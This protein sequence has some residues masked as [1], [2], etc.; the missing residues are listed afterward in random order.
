MSK[1][2]TEY[3]IDHCANVRKAYEWLVS[4][5][6]IA[7][8]FM[9]RIHTHDLSK[10]SDDEYGA[11]DKYFYGK[12]KT[13]EV[14]EAFNFAWLHHIHANPH[15]WQHWVLINDDDGTNALEMPEEYVVEML[16]DHLAFSFRENKLDEIFDWYKS[17]K[18]IMI[19][20]KKSR[21]LYES[22]LNKYKDSIKD[23]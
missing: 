11:Y 15:H 2:Y 9:H 20:H 23:A 5:K 12:E 21:E 22:L 4:H 7:D 18:N 13:K 6:I 3:I 10:Y 8:K 14:K 1:A 16:C 17:H 19:L